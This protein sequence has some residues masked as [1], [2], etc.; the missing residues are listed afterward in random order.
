M[1]RFLIT[2]LLLSTVLLVACSPTRSTPGRPTEQAFVTS[3]L[4]PTPIPMQTSNAKQMQS[5]SDMSVT[6]TTDPSILGKLFPNSNA[7]SELTRIDQQGMIVVEVT[8]SNLGTP[9]E[10]LIFEVALN[11]HSVDL[12][13]NLAKHATLMT[14]TDKVVQATGWDGPMVDITSVE[15]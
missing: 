9:G 14:D 2:L 10:T 12:S 5:T 11:T 1:K 8:P 3:T 6:P 7:G 4:P 15:N 13:F